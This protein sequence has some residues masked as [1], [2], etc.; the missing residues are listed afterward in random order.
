MFLVT[1]SCCLYARLIFVAAVQQRARAHASYVYQIV[2]MPFSPVI[3]AH[4]AEHTSIRRNTRVIVMKPY[5]SSKWPIF[6]Y[7]I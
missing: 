4:T 2:Y 6:F 5:F 1:F 3:C 7:R